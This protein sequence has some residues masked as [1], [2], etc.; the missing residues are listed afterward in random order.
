MTPEQE[1]SRIK[2]EYKE[3]WLRLEQHPGIKRAIAEN[4]PIKLGEIAAKIVHG[5]LS[6][7]TKEELTQAQSDYDDY[8]RYKERDRL[9]EQKKKTT[10]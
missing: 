1:I 2:K 3:H 9:I 10:S 5:N 6:K 8:L 4:D 7:P